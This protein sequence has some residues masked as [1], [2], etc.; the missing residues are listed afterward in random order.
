MSLNNLGVLYY[1]LGRHQEA[2]RM[3]DRASEIY[4]RLAEQNPVHSSLILR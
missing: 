4:Q 1:E 2:L 3:A